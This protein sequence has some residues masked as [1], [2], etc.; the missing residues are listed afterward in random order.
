MLTLLLM[1]RMLVLSLQ[2]CHCL[3]SVVCCFSCCQST[4]TCCCLSVA[5]AVVVVSVLA[6]VS[7][8]AAVVAAKLKLR[9]LQLANFQF[10]E[11][12][13]YFELTFV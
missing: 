12:S 9:N 4:F 10:L 8:V 3:H 2:Y 6:V 7:I 1:L 11:K 13:I 5:E